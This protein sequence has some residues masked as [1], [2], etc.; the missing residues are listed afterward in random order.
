MAT[1]FDQSFSSDYYSGSSNMDYN[2]YESDRIFKPIP[3]RYYDLDEYKVG[4]V[5]LYTVPECKASV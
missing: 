3:K 1:T 4:L 5:F 2:G